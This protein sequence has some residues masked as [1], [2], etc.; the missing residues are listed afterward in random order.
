MLG[1]SAIIKLHFLPRSLLVIFFLHALSVPLPRAERPVLRAVVQDRSSE[2][3]NS[4]VLRGV[5][6]H[7]CHHQV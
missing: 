2:M 4:A 3:E 1:V 7:L 6:F 5:Q